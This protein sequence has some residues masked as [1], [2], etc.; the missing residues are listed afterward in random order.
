[1]GWYKIA[2]LSAKMKQIDLKRWAEMH[3]LIIKKL[4][5]NVNEDIDA[6]I[7]ISDIVRE[8]V[9]ELN[10]FPHFSE[11]LSVWKSRHPEFEL[12]H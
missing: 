6:F 12:Q 9:D 8:L 10:R 3:R 1:M 7:E 11:F 4:G 5:I 2:G